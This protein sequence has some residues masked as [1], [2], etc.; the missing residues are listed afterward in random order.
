MIKTMFLMIII[1]FFINV[2]Y[3]YN[4]YFYKGYLF[5]KIVELMKIEIKNKERL[6]G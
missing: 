1:L 2:N 4:I 6:R 3:H 5:I